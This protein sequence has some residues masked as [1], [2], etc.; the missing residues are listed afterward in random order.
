MKGSPGSE[1]ATSICQAELSVL[2]RDSN[3]SVPYWGSSGCRQ[4]GRSALGDSQ[5]RGRMRPGP[6]QGQRWDFVL[7]HMPLLILLY[8]QE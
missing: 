1:L 8:R 7:E 2:I 4:L 6:V 5:G 3:L